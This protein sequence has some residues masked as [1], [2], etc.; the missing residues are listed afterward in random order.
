MKARKGLF[1]EWGAAKDL[2]TLSAYIC[3]GSMTV[4][5][6]AVSG[7]TLKNILSRAFDPV[8]ASFLHWLEGSD[9]LV[10]D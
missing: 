10:S 3:Q 1:H 7:K 2:K 5:V 8:N 9:G 6:N 4:V